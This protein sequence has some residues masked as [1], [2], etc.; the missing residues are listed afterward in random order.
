MAT[1]TACLYPIIAGL[2]AAHNFYF[3][4]TTPKWTPVNPQQVDFI[5]N[6]FNTN[7][8]ALR[9][10]SP[11]ELKTRANNDP[12]VINQWLKE[13][14]FD[15]QL[16]GERGPD[17]FFVAAILK[18][19]VEWLK[20]GAK[21]EF[22]C[23]LNR[24]AYQ[25]VRFEYDPEVCSVLRF[26]KKENVRIPIPRSGK[27]PVERG[28]VLKL[29]TKTDDV[30]YLSPAYAKDGLDKQPTCEFDL[31][32][33]INILRTELRHRSNSVDYVKDYM[34]CNAVFPMASINQ[35]NDVNWL[36]GLI[37]PLD[38]CPKVA[39]VKQ[40]TK[41][42]MDEK[43]AKVESAFAGGFV[44]E[45]MHQPDPDYL[46]NGPFYLWIERSNVN[47]PIFYAFIDV[48]SFKAFDDFPS[49]GASSSSSYH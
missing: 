28:D 21:G 36:V 24:N 18:V 37:S 29:A 23:P 34:G 6:V 43:G 20:N 25:S 31:I 19:V 1:I 41:F 13:S 5:E 3:S 27:I 47:L 44:N 49:Y 35:M 42:D 9:Y 8:D 32:N 17:K 48:D 7:L 4:G 46:I 26:H 14:G 45:C 10:F 16:G 15:I 30:V 38:P 39:E 33:R 12:A 2:V 11:E 40:Q 22:T